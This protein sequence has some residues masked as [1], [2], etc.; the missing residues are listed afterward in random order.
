MSL[1]ILQVMLMG[2]ILTIGSFVG[3]SEA[4]GHKCYHHRA[5]TCNRYSLPAYPYEQYKERLSSSVVAI[6]SVEQPSPITSYVLRTEAERTRQAI[7]VRRKDFPLL[8]NSVSAGGVTLERMGFSLYDTGQ[9]VCTGLLRF[10]GGPDGSLLGANV[11]VRVRAYSGAPQHPGGLTNMRLLW[12]TERAFWLNRG[13]AVTVSLLPNPP[14]VQP[15]FATPVRVHLEHSWPYPPSDL[16]YQHF[17]ETTHLE[18]ELEYRKD[19]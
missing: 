14:R 5:T 10:D 11:V 13:Q 4:K 16:I 2:G 9:H 12:E 3:L 7:G 8:R 19:R 17:G 15:A 6:A 1:K 18:V